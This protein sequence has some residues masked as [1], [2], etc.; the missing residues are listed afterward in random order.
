MKIEWDKR[1]PTRARGPNKSKRIKGE[2]HVDGECRVVT[3][4]KKYELKQ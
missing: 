3:E 1:K 2:K 4:G